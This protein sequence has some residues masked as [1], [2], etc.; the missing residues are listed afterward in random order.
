MT[1]RI[2]TDLSF[3]SSSTIR[4][5]SE[6]VSDTKTEEKCLILFKR[7]RLILVQVALFE[8]SGGLYDAENVKNVRWVSYLIYLSIGSH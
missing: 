5:I 4:T 3:F 8:L 1:Q 7:V 2:K 6:M